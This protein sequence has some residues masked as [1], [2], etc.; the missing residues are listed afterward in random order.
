MKVYLVTKQC[1]NDYI[2]YDVFDNKE[3]AY[4]Y[5]YKIYQKDGGV[6]NY[7]DFLHYETYTNYVESRV[8]NKTS[9][10]DRFLED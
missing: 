6:L 10:L 2:I 8:V 4:E 7:E 1:P 9:H 3:Q 5:S